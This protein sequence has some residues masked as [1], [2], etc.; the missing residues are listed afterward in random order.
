LYDVTQFADM[1]INTDDLGRIIR[2]KDVASIELWRLRGVSLGGFAV[3]A[4]RLRG[5]SLCFWF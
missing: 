1:I 3:S 5:V 4:W 2:L